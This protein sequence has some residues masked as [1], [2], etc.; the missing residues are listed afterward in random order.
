MDII[1]LI[2]AAFKSSFTLKDVCCRDIKDRTYISSVLRAI[3]KLGV[4]C[5]LLY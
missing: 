3:L 1:Y 4:K 2:R 5:P